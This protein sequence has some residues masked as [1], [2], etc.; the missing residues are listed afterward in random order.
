MEVVRELL[1]HARR[2]G[3]DKIR[4]G[5]DNLASS[6]GYPLT[7]TATCEPQDDKVLSLYVPKPTKLLKERCQRHTGA[8]F[9]HLS[10]RRCRRHE[11]DALGRLT[12]VACAPLQGPRLWDFYTS[13]LPWAA[14]GIPGPSAHPLGHIRT[15]GR[16]PL[17]QLQDLRMRESPSI[18]P[19]GRPRSDG[20]S[21]ARRLQ[22]Q[23]RL[24]LVR[25]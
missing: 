22:R 19:R 25:D 18:I 17:R 5:C 12:A 2:K 8:S 20:P 6:L 9:M 21:C 24:G 10:D 15:F 11:R 23:V 1:H 16:G 4:S 14:E 13:T 7:L 3:E